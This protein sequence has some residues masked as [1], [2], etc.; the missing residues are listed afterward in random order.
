MNFGKLKKIVEILTKAGVQDREY[1]DMKHDI[2]Y[3]PYRETGTD[4]AVDLENENCH[5]D[6]SADSW[7]SF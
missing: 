2:L 4:I 5:F 6:K 7:A 3:L 1:F